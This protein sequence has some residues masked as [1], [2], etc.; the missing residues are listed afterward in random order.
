MMAPLSLDSQEVVNPMG[1]IIKTTVV[2]S[3]LVSSLS[4]VSL[5]PLSKEMEAIETERQ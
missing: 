4:P 3:S 2:T 5:W 1:A